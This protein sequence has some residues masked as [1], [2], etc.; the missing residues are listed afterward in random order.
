MIGTQSD[1]TELDMRGVAIWGVKDDLLQWGESITNQCRE[2]RT[3]PGKNSSPPR[4]LTSCRTPRYHLTGVAQT[5]LSYRSIQRT[6]ASLIRAC[7]SACQFCQLLRCAIL[8]DE[9]LISCG[10]R[11]GRIWKAGYAV[12][13]VEAAFTK[14][15]H[16]GDSSIK[17]IALDWDW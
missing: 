12:A 7:Y 17:S 5:I 8:S 6:S 13:L 2:V 15:M 9:R 16:S 3:S 14:N 4:R 1:G 10:S 11:N